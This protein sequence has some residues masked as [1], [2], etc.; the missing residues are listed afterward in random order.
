LM[1]VFREEWGMR[2]FLT[3]ICLLFVGM[4]GA[5]CGSDSGEE[6]AAANSGARRPA[7]RHGPAVTIIEEEAPSILLEAESGELKEPVKVFEDEGASG[8]K[9]VL[10]PEGPEHKEISIGGQATYAFRV[11]TTGR[12]TLWLRTRFSGACGNSLGVSLDG[13][14]LGVVEDAVY[15]KWHWVPLRSRRVELAAGRH[16]LVIS[17]REDGAAWDQV[18]FAADKRYR[19]GGIERAD[20][21]GRTSGAIPAADVSGAR[22]AESGE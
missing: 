17:N 2:A 14:T 21:P 11:E 8:G 12:Y 19:P 16:V 13:R 1:R 22:E 7:N 9:F 20:V 4:C 6:G 10:A 18:L 5:G 15:E 3:V